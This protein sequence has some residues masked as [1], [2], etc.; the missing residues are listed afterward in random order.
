MSRSSTPPLGL[1]LVSVPLTSRTVANSPAFQALKASVAIG[2]ECARL[3][4]VVQTLATR[5]SGAVVGSC[6][7]SQVRSVITKFKMLCVDTMTYTAQ[8][9][10][11]LCSVNRTPSSYKECPMSELRSK[12]HSTELPI[13]VFVDGTRPKPASLGIN[14]V[15]TPVVDQGA[16]S[17]AMPAQSLVVLLAQPPLQSSVHALRITDSA[18]RIHVDTLLL[19]EVML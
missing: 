7:P 9:I 8:M 15:S 5:C 10:K 19:E 11:I 17:A 1:Q 4:C 13:T 18:H 14:Y 3:G 12:D 6:S 2:A 16:V